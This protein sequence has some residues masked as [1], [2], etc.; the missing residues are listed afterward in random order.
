[1]TKVDHGRE[2]AWWKKR[3]AERPKRAEAALRVALRRQ[4]PSKEQ[5]AP[6]LGKAILRAR[7]KVADLLLHPPAWLRDAERL[8]ADAWSRMKP[9]TTAPPS[10]ISPQEFAR[11]LA[12][13][14]VERNRVV[15]GYRGGEDAAHPKDAPVDPED[16][17]V[18]G[19][20]QDWLNSVTPPCDGHGLACA[21]RRGPGNQKHEDKCDSQK[22]RDQKRAATE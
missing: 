2:P 16:G 19:T 6:P 18:W 9:G 17:S 10:L 3:D 15:D 8:V 22:R 7:R 20:R 12:A 13:T 21:A 1:M 5:P 4:W 14:A 11:H